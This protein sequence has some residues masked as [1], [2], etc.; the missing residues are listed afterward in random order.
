MLLVSMSQVSVVSWNVM[1][2]GYAKGY[3]LQRAVECM[4]RMQSSGVEPDEVT[5]VNMLA[6][7]LRSGDDETGLR[8]FNGMS[9]PGLASWNAMLSGYSQNEYHR[10]AVMLYRE[11]QFRKVRPDR[12][13]F[14][15]ILSSCASMG[16]LESG[17]QIHDALWKAELSMDLYVRVD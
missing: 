16:L 8:I 14:A 3:H 10:E 5:C 13:T 7:C 12:T 9:V 11:M 17:K 15:I 6:A 1:I 4:E 2:A